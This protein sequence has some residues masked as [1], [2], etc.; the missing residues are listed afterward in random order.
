MRYRGQFGGNLRRRGE[1]RIQ[2]DRKTSEVL[3][4]TIESSGLA[5]PRLR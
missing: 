3:E 1:E 5:I 4:A 2:L